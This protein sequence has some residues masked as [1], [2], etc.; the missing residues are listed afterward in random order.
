[1]H[2]RS[3]SKAGFTLIELS[4]VITVIGLVIGGIVLGKSLI[5]NSQLVAVGSEYAK[6][7][8][9]INNFR[10][11]YNALPGDFNGATALWGQASATPAGCLS[12]SLGHNETCDGNGDGRVVNM[13]D[14]NNTAYEQFRAWQHLGN[15]QMVEGNFTGLRGTSGTY[16]RNPG[17][18]V[19]ASRLSGA[20]WT[21]FT[22]TTNDISAGAI[23][24]SG[25]PA[26]N[27][28]NADIRPNHVLWLGGGYLEN[29]LRTKPVMTNVE[30]LSLD[31][32]LDDGQPLTGKIIVQN[33]NGLTPKCTDGF[34]SYDPTVTGV[35]CALVFKTDL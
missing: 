12:T 19:P 17:V 1:M 2:T 22:V 13:Q 27:Y 16:H 10:S 15:A 20:G 7:T 28:I 31:Q 5:R 4:V 25:V 32:K 26:I 34:T 23:N 33:S 21:F 24:V 30:A 3:F 8:Q 35:A 11:K 14:Y 29:S 18:N 9:A 6:Y